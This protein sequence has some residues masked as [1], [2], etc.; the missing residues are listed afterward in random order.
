VTAVKL[1]G[2]RTFSSLRAHRNYRL[3]FAGQIVSLCG[4][5]TQNVALY[6]L[7][8]DLTRS[9]VAVGLISLARFGP[10]SVLG[11]FSGV[12]ADRFDN[13]RTVIA[14]QSVQMALSAVLAAITLLGSV[15]PWEV[16]AI[17]ALI[18]TAVVFDLPARQNLIVQLVGRSELPNAIALNSSLANTAR[19]FGPALAGVLIATAGTGWCF[20]INSASFLAV[21]AGLVAMRTSELYPLQ[22]RVRPT[23]WRGTREG[24]AYARRTRRVVV[25]LGVAVVVVS[26]SFNVNVLLPVLARET[27]HAGPRTLGIISACFGIGALAGALTSAAIAR[28]RWRTILGGA[29]L[30]GLAEL[31]IAPLHGVLAV[32]ALLFLCGFCFTTY[33]SSSN[34]SVQ[35]QTPDHIRGRV[36]GIYFYAWNGPSAL[37]SPL[38]GWLCAVG[39]T[40]L[41]FTFA[42]GS[43]LVATAAGALAIARPWRRRALTRAEA[44]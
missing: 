18:G 29:G 26:F 24:I 3:Y 43:A 15:H 23:L 5:W 6:W 32:G 34:A 21:L 1:A 14:T 35:L 44:A 30:F 39:G 13:R 42:G 38:L 31:A 17:A 19:V 16:Y 9:P 27:L 22:D 40:S 2:R 8:L 10:F 41:A 28:P 11:L 33:T 4:T 7:I 12:V 25:L 20:A 37:A 36:L